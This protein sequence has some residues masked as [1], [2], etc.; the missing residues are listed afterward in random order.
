MGLLLPGHNLPS[1]PAGFNRI[2]AGG[3]RPANHP[4]L[5]VRAPGT[6]RFLVMNVNLYLI[7]L[8][9]LLGAAGAWRFYRWRWRPRLLV[10]SVP[11]HTSSGAGAVPP[12]GDVAPDWLL[13]VRNEGA[14]TAKRCR[15]TLLRLST[16]EHGRWV[17]VEPDST[18]CPMTWSDGSVERNLAP[19]EAADLLVMRGHELQPGQ[20]RFEVAVINGEERRVTFEIAVPRADRSEGI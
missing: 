8:V 10:D 9:V 20:Y 17:R 13:R 4:W 3:A 1:R 19:A 15:A 14:A 12:A 16:Q 2:R 6:H 5:D 18:A 7:S 11:R